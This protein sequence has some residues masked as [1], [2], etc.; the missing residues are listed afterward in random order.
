[1]KKD[2]RIV[3]ITGLAAIILTISL[4]MPSKKDNNYT[5]R[6]DIMRANSLETYLDDY[7][8]LF[9]NEQD[10]TLTDY[11]Y[12]KSLYNSIKEGVNYNAFTWHYKFEI[13]GN[14]PIIAAT[15]KEENGKVVYYDSNEQPVRIESGSKITIY[16]DSK[17]AYEIDKDNDE[18]IIIEKKS[19][20]T[21]EELKI[22]KDNS[23]SYR[24]GD[25]T[26]KFDQKGLLKEKSTS[27]SKK[28][29]ED[30]N[31]NV[32][33][34][35][36]N[37]K[38][39]QKKRKDGTIQEIYHLE[40]PP[41]VIDKLPFYKLNRNFT[42]DVDSIYVEYTTSGC[43]DSILFESHEERR[44]FEATM[45]KDGSFQ[46]TIIYRDEAN[47]ITKEEIFECNENQEMTITSREFQNE[48]INET[49]TSYTAEERI[50]QKIVNSHEVMALKG[51][52]VYIFNENHEIE[53]YHV[54][55][56]K[57][58]TEYNADG[59]K[60]SYHDIENDSYTEYYPS[61]KI[62]TIN[63][64]EKCVSYYETGATKSFLSYKNNVEV[65]I[66]GKT[67]ILNQNDNYSLYP[68]GRLERL[69]KAENDKKIST[70]YYESGELEEQ[71][72]NGNG[73][74]YYISGKVK[75]I[76]ENNQVK[77]SYYETGEIKFMITPT[78]YISYYQNGSIEKTKEN[79]ITTEYR[80]NRIYS[81]KQSKS[82]VYYP[83][84]EDYDFYIVENFNQE[85]IESL[86]KY[87]YIYKNDLIYTSDSWEYYSYNY[88]EE[89]GL[90]NILISCNNELFSI[91]ID[92]NYYSNSK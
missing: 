87:R 59:T 21:N 13:P 45:Q 37:G 32:Y 41:D 57:N 72:V 14:Q 90:T 27:F 16:I 28:I 38:I 62:K 65:K 24:Y 9:M 11:E 46:A 26:F 36:R 60:L 68:S 89:Y 34:E 83:I 61:G 19:S 69:E 85:D 86:G 4:K 76:I 64:Q 74:S 3:I 18:S 54:Y 79:G 63:N 39:V 30:G 5:P 50:K 25:A 43:I 6:L 8:Q 22:K 47:H 70:A 91:Y 78:G 44:D 1:M 56:G 52:I 80:D 20:T 10:L 33:S 71:K 92:E 82:K 35:F 53:K 67:Y 2:R 77:T 42:G 23:Y 7:Q 88:V 66:A 40:L 55:D 12:Y 48:N 58:Y 49:I 31:P 81:V 84:A 51:N 29:Y 75:S 17:N 15:K 73:E